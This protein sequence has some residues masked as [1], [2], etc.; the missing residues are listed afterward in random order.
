MMFLKSI[1]TVL[2]AIISFFNS[3]VIGKSPADSM[4][5]HEFPVIGVESKGDES[6]TRIMSFNVRCGDVNGVPAA[7]RKDVVVKQILA[8]QP[9][10]F[11]VQEAN[12]FWMNTLKTLLPQYACVG[13]DRDQGRKNGTGEHAAVF[14]LKSKFKAL[15]SGDFWLSETPDVPSFGPGAGCRRVCT[16]VILE[17]R[18]TKAKFV[19]VNTHFDHVSEEARVLAGNFVNDY[20]QEHFSALPVVFSADMNT[21]EGGE[22]YLT[23]TKNLDNTR[24]KAA[25]SVGFGTFHACSPETH[26][27][28][29]IDFILCSKDVEVD[30]YR[31]V[32]EG[33]DGRFVS[34][35]FPIYADLVIP[36]A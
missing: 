36:A 32:T 26:A 7:N 13:V 11:G 34:D 25:D 27:S 9:D 33:I 22:A 21:G 16:W 4:A 6:L 30:A 19:Y 23:M 14:Y 29:F 35:H 24:L 18:D 5:G 28:Y 12:P 31:T 1:A 17:N 2:L 3:M 20:I 8:V 15:D 10:A